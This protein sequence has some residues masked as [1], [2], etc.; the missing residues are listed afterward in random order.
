MIQR[1]KYRQISQVLHGAVKP[2]TQNV[3]IFDLDHCLKVFNRSN[4]DGARTFQYTLLKSRQPRQGRDT[5]YVDLQTTLPLT[6]HIK[7]AELKAIFIKGRIW[8]TNK[9][10][11]SRK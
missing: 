2:P 8:R 5:H 4:R 1:K 3:V 6:I 9:V 10:R 11:L 7:T